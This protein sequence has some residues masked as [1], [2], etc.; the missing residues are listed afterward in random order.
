MTSIPN[1]FLTGLVETLSGTVG[2]T[3]GFDFSTLN[4]GDKA[5]VVGRSLDDSLTL[6]A[7][8][9]ATRRLV[10]INHPED[11]NHDPIGWAVVTDHTG[12]SYVEDREPYLEAPLP[13][14]VGVLDR[15]AKHDNQIAVELIVAGAQREGSGQKING[16]KAIRALTNASL[17]D[18]KNAYEAIPLTRRQWA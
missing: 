16:I 6:V 10:F 14:Y 5:K 12:R 18:A 3:V 1:P 15:L 4:I 13:G 17:V 2:P 8:D 11:S 9:E 7:K